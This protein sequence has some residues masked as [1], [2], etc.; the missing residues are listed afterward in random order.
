M[1]L[2]ATKTGLNYAGFKPEVRDLA[3]FQDDYGWKAEDG[4]EDGV[5]EDDD[6]DDED[7]DEDDEDDEDDDTTTKQ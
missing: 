3:S 6:D 2:Q 5:E 1:H 4:E 7:D